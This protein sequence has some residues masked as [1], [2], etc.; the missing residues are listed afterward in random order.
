MNIPILGRRAVLGAV[1]I[2][3]AL[4]LVTAIALLLWNLLTPAYLS[5]TIDWTGRTCPPSP[6]LSSTVTSASSEY[7]ITCELRCST[8]AS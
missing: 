7:S 1:A 4:L 2:V 3:V 8:D 5:G 6:C